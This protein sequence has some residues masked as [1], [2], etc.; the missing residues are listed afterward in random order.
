MYDMIIAGA[1]PAGSILAQGLGKKYKVLLLDKRRLHGETMDPQAEKCCGGLLDPSAQKA[2]VS[3]HIG[4]PKNVLV[5]PQVFAI[6]ALDFE[7]HQE[8]YYQKQY[9]NVDRVLFDRYLV[10][11][12]E[13]R[14]GVTLW[15][16]TLLQNFTET[17]DGVQVQVLH[18]PT[19]EVREIKA[20]YL[21]GADGAASVVRRLKGAGENPAS[22]PPREYV[23]FQQWFTM[24]EELPY[25]VSAFDRYITD[26]YSW[27]IPKD[28]KLIVGTA[29]PKGPDVRVKFE[30][31]KAQ[32]IAAGIPLGEPVY[33]SGAVMLRPWPFGSIDPGSGR[34]LLIGEAAGLISPSS[35]EGI[36]YA[37]KSAAALAEVFVKGSKKPVDIAYAEKLRGLKLNICYK[38]M[39][40]TIMYNPVLRGLVFKSGL[41][42]TDIKDMVHW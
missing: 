31:L 3:L 39:K 9:V 27:A 15:D 16:E 11:L 28:G 35:A 26:F 8:R 22:N 10:K 33:E 25:F 17:A 14:E 41:L 42:S 30:C 7:N 21:I 37:I 2:L 34:V 20:R 6:R 32:L 4:I 5:S 19:G 12:A 24:K 38:S 23:C 13:K 18:K 29:I 36:S 40:S 1:G